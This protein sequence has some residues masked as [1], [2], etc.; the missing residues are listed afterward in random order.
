[1]IAAQSVSTVASTLTHDR[2]VTS[3][4]HGTCAIVTSSKFQDV[5]DWYKANLPQGW[6]TQTVGDLNSLA[7]QVSITNIM[8]T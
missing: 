2:L 4:Y 7:Q 1:L 6:Q 8:S 3:Q 5:V